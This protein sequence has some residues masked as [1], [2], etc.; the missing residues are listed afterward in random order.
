M[1]QLSLFVVALVVDVVRP[2]LGL[3]T[4]GEADFSGSIVRQDGRYLVE[5]EAGDVIARVGSYREGAVK[6][7]RHHGV[8]STVLDVTVEFERIEL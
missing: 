2:G 1:D 3:V 8:D 5:S 4:C 6:L 7:A